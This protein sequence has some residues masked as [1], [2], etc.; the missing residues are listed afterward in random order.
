M[1]STNEKSNT[2]SFT[3]SEVFNSDN[4]SNLSNQPPIEGRL[5]AA[6]AITN[7]HASSPMDSKT[8]PP[9]LPSNASAEPSSKPTGAKSK[10]KNQSQK[11]QKPQSSI[12]QFLAPTT[13]SKQGIGQRVRDGLEQVLNT[14]LL[15]FHPHQDL[16]TST[17]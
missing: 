3:T 12:Q 10:K 8:P 5:S 6:L 9:S 7:D 1:I 16:P 2:V 15:K 13:T 17:V 4:L 11:T 14:K